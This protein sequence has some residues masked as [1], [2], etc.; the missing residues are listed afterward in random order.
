MWFKW[1][2]SACFVIEAFVSSAL[3]D[4]RG[5]LSPQWSIECVRAR[6]EVASIDIRLCVD[7]RLIALLNQ[8]RLDSKKVLVAEH[9]R[10]EARRRA[11]VILFMF[12]H[13]D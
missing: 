8:K 10:D 13:W 5:N 4:Y 7:H 6:G 2:R 9:K 11:R 1:R 3:T 12:M